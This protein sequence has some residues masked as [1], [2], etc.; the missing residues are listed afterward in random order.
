MVAM[1]PNIFRLAHDE[2][3]GP[4]TV[5]RVRS[6][7]ATSMG[8][9]DNHVW[10]SFETL[11]KQLGHHADL[12]IEFYEDLSWLLSEGCF[13]PDRRANCFLVVSTLSPAPGGLIFKA[14]LKV[15][16]AN[17]RIMLLS[18]HRIGASDI[19]RLLKRAGK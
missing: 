15:V 13:L 7:F 19:R 2:I 14:T 10:L 9:G 17:G 8:A 12:R 4:I 6:S 18:V 11:R 16:K 3:T 5:G 1:T